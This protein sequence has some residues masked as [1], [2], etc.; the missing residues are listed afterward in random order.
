MK[1][2]ISP[3]FPYG[4]QR[5][6]WIISIHRKNNRF[7]VFHTK[8]EISW[9]HPPLFKFTWVLEIEL[10]EDASEITNVTVVITDFSIED[11]VPEETKSNIK[12]AF[13]SIEFIDRIKYN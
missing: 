7:F 10:N 3:I 13:N 11:F 2:I 1:H 12:K 8:K 9:A 6:E 4:D 5:G